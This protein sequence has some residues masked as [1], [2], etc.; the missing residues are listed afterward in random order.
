MMSSPV[1]PQRVSRPVPSTPVQPST[2]FNTV[3]QVRDLLELATEIRRTERVSRRTALRTAIHLSAA[4]VEDVAADAT[5]RPARIVMFAPD[6]L[7]IR[8]SEVLHA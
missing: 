3:D 4:L 5:Y 6:G 7:P 8:A 2:T 1:E